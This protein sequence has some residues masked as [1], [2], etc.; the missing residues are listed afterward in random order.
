MPSASSASTA[1]A[2]S[3]AAM[4][5]SASAVAVAAS[6]ISG[7]VDFALLSQFLLDIGE[8]KFC[9]NRVK[10]LPPVRLGGG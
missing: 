6:R 2:V 4:A 1:A 8:S 7:T 9:I 3:G 10:N 5:A